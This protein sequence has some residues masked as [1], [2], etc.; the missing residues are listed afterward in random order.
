MARPASQDGFLPV[1][2]PSSAVP[3]RIDEHYD[4]DEEF[5][6]A[7]ADALNEEYRAVVDAGLYVQVDDAY[8]ATMYDNMVPPATMSD[9]RAWAELRV[10][11]LNR[12]LDGIPPERA[13]YHVLLGQL[14]RPAQHATSRCARSSTSCSRC[15][16]AATR[17]SR[18]T[19][20]TSTSGRCGATSSCPTTRCCSPGSS[21]TSRTSSSTP[22]SSRSASSASPSSSGASAS[23]PAPT[24]ASP[25]RRT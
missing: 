16:S 19:R 22:S 12:A 15:R 3:I 17:S 11:A 14:E 2:A 25:R 21:A 10:E 23:S 18:P 5:I 9:Y 1:V 6:F 4:S 8:M 20:A 13:R 24:A 7:L